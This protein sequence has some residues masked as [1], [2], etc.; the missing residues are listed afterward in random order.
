MGARI[1]QVALRARAVFKI[2]RFTLN[3]SPGK[4]E[5]L[6]AYRGAEAKKMRLLLF[7][8]RDE[9]FLECGEDQ[10]GPLIVFVATEGGRTGMNIRRETSQYMPRV[11]RLFWA[12]LPP[13]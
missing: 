7:R 3:F 5:F 9:G 2:F 6:I 1:A 10:H 8:R 11:S 4:S 13:R 12:A